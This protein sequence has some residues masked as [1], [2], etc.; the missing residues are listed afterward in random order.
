M[1]KFCRCVKLFYM[2]FELAFGFNFKEGQKFY[3]YKKQKKSR[4]NKNIF[5]G[6]PHISLW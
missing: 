2:D 4:L 6:F 3:K 5:Y 1:G